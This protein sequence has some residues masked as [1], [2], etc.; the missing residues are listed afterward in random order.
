MS[1]RPY[2]NSHHSAG[3]SL[4]EVAVSVSILSVLLGAVGLFQVRSQ[5]ASR[6]MQRRMDLER[7]ADRT[8]QTIAHELTGAGVHT[9]VPDPT[10]VFGTDTL[11]FQ[12]P[13]AVSAAGVVTWSAPTRIA[14]Q[15]EDGETINGFDDNNN[16]LVDERE[17]LII[18]GVGTASEN[19]V[20]A[21]HRVGRWL[22]GETTNGVDDNG[23][24]IIDEHGFCVRR[25]GDLLYLY[26]TLEGP[27]EGGSVTRWSTSTAV[28][29]HN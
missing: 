9:L 27:T 1:S 16:G 7:R 18:R 5:S 14:L 3:F 4:V 2:C 17:I 29:L 10:S 15:I 25:V 26:L 19:T 12:K 22:E 8:L 20:V 28:V 6:V 11:T 13:V 23:N 24:G 21:S